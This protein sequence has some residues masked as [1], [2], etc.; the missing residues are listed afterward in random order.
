[1]I[2]IQLLE[3]QDVLQG[4][5]WCRPLILQ[6]MSGGMS[7]SYSFECEWS[8]KPENNT[9]WVNVSEIFPN[10]IGESVEHV[11][12]SL[13]VCQA[14]VPY[15]FVRGNIPVQHQY[16]KTKRQRREDYEQ[17]LLNTEM[18]V[19]KYKG[20]SMALVKDLNPKYFY[21]AQGV[22]IVKDIRNFS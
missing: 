10:W 9:K 19:G 13:Q 18:P 6:T 14:F 4:T 5:D 7:D 17:Y 22:G 2:Q 3:P 16:G 11:I 20:K 12:N 21:W 8:G 1:M 15:E